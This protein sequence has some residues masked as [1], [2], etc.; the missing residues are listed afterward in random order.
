MIGLVL[1]LLF[2][3][4]MPSQAQR[5]PIGAP[6][7][8]RSVGYD[9]RLGVRIPLNLLF[10]D[11]AG[12]EVRLRQYFGQRPVVLALVYYECP[13]LCN[14]VLNGLLRAFRMLSFDIGK[15]YE[16]VTVSI[17]PRETPALA[18][19]KKQSYL[20]G[21][22]RESAGRGWH[23][24][25]GQEPSIAALAQSVGFRYTYDAAHGQYAHAAGI[26][27][28]T[29]EGRVARYQFGVEYSPRDLRLSLIEASNDR[30]GTLVD[31]AL[32]YC[33]S[34]DPATGR[35]GAVVMR[36]I[37][38]GAVITVLLLGGM[39]CLFLWRERAAGTSQ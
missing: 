14:L 16:V 28:L 33:F 24:L 21:Y 15:Q 9:Q 11:E 27:V 3:S 1:L 19:R 13:N 20:E 18:A 22:R 38:A 17:D 6:P 35:Y 39:V 7:V 25:T 36:L 31:D 8:L 10:R 5:K 32:L 34:Y 29:P 4:A 37:R 26:V 23:F 2:G 12:S 30:I